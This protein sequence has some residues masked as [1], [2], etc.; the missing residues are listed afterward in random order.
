MVTAPDAGDLIWIEPGETRGRE[1]R[2]RRPAL[3]LS[4]RIYNEAAE[5]CVVCPIT[6]KA[7]GYTF[8]SLMPPG[9]LPDASVVMADQVRSISWI[10]RAFGVIGRAPADLLEDVREKV[11]AL[12]GLAD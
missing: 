5:L 9:L 4:S 8:E 6:S 3:V 1:Q 2:G 12:I 10:H 11:A 7:H